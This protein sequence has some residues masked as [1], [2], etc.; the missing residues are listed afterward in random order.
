MRQGQA[1]WLTLH[2]SGDCGSC[3]PYRFPKA[4]CTPTCS[5]S[6]LFT[7]RSCWRCLRLVGRASAA[8]V[9]AGLGVRQV[10][11]SGAR[12]CF[13]DFLLRERGNVGVVLTNPH[14]PRGCFARPGKGY[15]YCHPIHKNR[16]NISTGHRLF[17][18]CHVVYCPGAPPAASIVTQV[19]ARVCRVCFEGR[20]ARRQRCSLSAFCI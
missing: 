2:I 6:L 16:S 3:M 12:V 8:H 19:R 20:H 17:S 1:S 5:P 4:P 13:H 15:F 18:E 10:K 11:T 7:P 9:S 14:P